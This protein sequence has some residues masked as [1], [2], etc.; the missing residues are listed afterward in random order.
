MKEFE[1]DINEINRSGAWTPTNVKNFI[2]AD[3]LQKAT[4]KEKAFIKTLVN[5]TDAE[6][7]YVLKEIGK[8]TNFEKFN[9]HT[10]SHAIRNLMNLNGRGVFNIVKMKKPFSKNQLANLREYFKTI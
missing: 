7:N 1:L 10:S 6:L 9:F 5:A 4:K 2:E 3:Y 8:K